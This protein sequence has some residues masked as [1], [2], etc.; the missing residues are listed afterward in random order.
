MSST[1]Y[2]VLIGVCF[3]K[4][5]LSQFGKFINWFLSSEQVKS[6][7]ETKYYRSI[8]ATEQSNTDIN[9]IRPMILK[10]KYIVPC[11]Y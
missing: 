8:A 4:R 9:V 10:K 3:L 7:Y 5:G 1:L 6:T 11:K 2:K